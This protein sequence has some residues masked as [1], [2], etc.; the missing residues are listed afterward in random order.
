MTEQPYPDS[1]PYLPERPFRLPPKHNALQRLPE[2]NLTQWAFHGVQEHPNRSS[3]EEVITFQSCR[4]H[5]TKQPYPDN[6]PYLTDFW[7]NPA[8]TALQRHS[9]G[10]L[11]QWYFH[12]V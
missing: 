5:K 12:G 9:D 8:P 3:D 10:N 1:L 11:T 6:L 4:S 7:L 2:G